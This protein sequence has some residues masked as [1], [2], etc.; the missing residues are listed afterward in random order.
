ME[1]HILVT[2]GS[3]FIGRHI[4][5]TAASMNIPVV[6]ISRSGRPKGLSNNYSHMIQWMKADVFRPHTWSHYLKDCRA[7]IH[8]VA[9][10]FQDSSK[11]ITHDKFIYQSACIAGNEAMKAHIPKFVFISAAVIPFFSSKSYNEAK[12]K[13]E[14]YLSKLNFELVILRPSLIY[15]NEKPIITILSV[16]LNQFGKVPVFKKVVLPIRALS[17]KMLAKAAV[18]AANEQSVKGILNIDDIIYVSQLFQ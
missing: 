7:V 11:D 17:V 14:D 10:L 8:C 2:G 16:V 15:G 5:T 1:G 13:A 6:S 9:I 3:G 12:R 4:C 18:I